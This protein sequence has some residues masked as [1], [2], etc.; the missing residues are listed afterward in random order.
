MI[1]LDA[2]GQRRRSY[3]TAFQKLELVL[4]WATLHFVDAM[5]GY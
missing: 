1:R 3:E 2:C 5:Q 4:S